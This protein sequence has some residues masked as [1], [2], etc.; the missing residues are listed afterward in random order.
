M[1]EGKLTEQERNE[2][3]GAAYGDEEATED[4]IDA[5]TE[6][7]GE[8]AEDSETTEFESGSESGSESE[9]APPPVMPVSIPVP[10]A[11]VL[12]KVG[13]TLWGRPE[14]AKPSPANDMADLF[15]VPQSEDNDMYI[16]DLFEVPDE[17]LDMDDDLDDDLSDLTSVSAEDVMGRKP[18]PRMKFARTGKP[19]IPPVSMGGTR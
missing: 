3:S 5:E 12:G 1:P 6:A 15:E 2:L 18:K 8:D 16:D 7:V 14:P 9:L 4:A 11:P 19:Y 13:D 17:E 10:V